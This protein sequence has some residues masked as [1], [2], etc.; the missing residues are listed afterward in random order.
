MPIP[1]M[2]AH[3]FS[4][5]VTVA[6]N[7]TIIHWKSPIH[8][9]KPWICCCKWQLLL[10]IPGYYKF[11]KLI[12]LIFDDCSQILQQ[13][14]QNKKRGNIKCARVVSGDAYLPNSYCVNNYWEGCS[15]G[16]VCKLRILWSAFYI[17]ASLFWFWE[18]FWV[19]PMK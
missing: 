12:R 8:N 14:N 5:T 3:L 15:M 7:V 6:P 11:R 18:L 17:S 16:I 10:L 13:S 19:I 9:A 4:V 1:R 2:A